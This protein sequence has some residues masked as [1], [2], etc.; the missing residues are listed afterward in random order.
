MILSNSIILLAASGTPAVH[1]ESLMP[2]IGCWLLS[3]T[4]LCLGIIGMENLLVTL[5]ESQ[6][7]VAQ[8]QHRF[9]KS[10][11][12]I[13]AVVCDADVLLTSELDFLEPCPK[14]QDKL[15]PIDF[16][17][18]SSRL[19]NFAAFVSGAVEKARFLNF[20]STQEASV[21]HLAAGKTHVPAGSLETILIA[22]DG[23]EVPASIYDVPISNQEG[24]KCR[25]LLGIKF[26]EQEAQTSGSSMDLGFPSFAEHSANSKLPVERLK[27]KLTTDPNFSLREASLCVKLSYS[28]N[29][30]SVFE[31]MHMKCWEE[32]CRWMLK[33]GETPTGTQE[34]AFA[35]TEPMTVYHPFDPHM[36]LVFS[37]THVEQMEDPD[38]LVIID[39]QGARE[40]MD[41]G[42]NKAGLEV[43]QNDAAESVG[44]RTLMSDTFANQFRLQ[45][46][47][48]GELKD[49]LSRVNAKPESFQKKLQKKQKKL[50]L[51]RRAEESEAPKPQSLGLP[52]PKETATAAPLEMKQTSD[53]SDDA[54]SESTLSQ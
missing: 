40:Q 2:A 9:Q 4:G 34:R 31:F 27:L 35:Y 1:N 15:E 49:F 51:Q 46:R 5:V 13:L 36:E 11:R 21:E 10:S 8:E 53:D 23:S 33:R 44:G 24:Q 6:F 42:T 30:P 45:G 32:L 52:R 19:P 14:L 29:P 18:S 26:K 39:M 3:G 38:D 43:E 48:Q 16:R 54:W 28:K 22:A 7:L 37:E 50:E 47:H 17:N 20:M 12:S 41:P 25:H